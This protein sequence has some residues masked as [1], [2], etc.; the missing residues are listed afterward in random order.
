MSATASKSLLLTSEERGKVLVIDDSS[1][2]R[3]HSRKVA[4]LA[5]LYDHVENRF[6]NGF[7]MLTPGLV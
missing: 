5:R 7:R 2:D 3:W 4:L 1:Y 6:I